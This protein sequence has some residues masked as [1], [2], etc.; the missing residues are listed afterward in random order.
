M[1]Y[2]ILENGP[3]PGRRFSLTGESVTIGRLG[4][5][6]LAVG[7]SVVLFN[8]ELLAVSRR[9]AR[10]I[11]RGN[12]W[13]VMDGAEEGPSRN[14][15]Y[16]NGRRL[17]NQL[18]PVADGDRL[19]LCEPCVVKLAFWTHLPLPPED[20][21][22][23]LDG[24]PPNTVVIDGPLAE[25]D[26]SS[27]RILSRVDARDSALGRIPMTA[28]LES[29]FQAVL[30]IM[31]SL[32]QALGLDDVLPQVLNSL[33]KLF[34]QTDRGVIVLR[35][36][37][38]GLAPR[39]W[40]LRDAG[41]K[42]PRI[43]RS[44]AR[45]VMDTKHAARLEDW[46]KES[47]SST[48]DLRVRSVMCTPLLDAKGEPL[49]VMQLDTT[50]ANRRFTQADLEL[51]ATV[52]APAGIAVDNA[53]LH[54]RALRQQQIEFDLELANEVLLSFLP[55]RRPQLDDYEFFDF[56]R[57]ANR[58]GGD[59]FDYLTLPDGR[60]A[61]LVAD[62]VGKGVAA[63][64]MM[65]RVSGE[66]KFCLA[67][68][69]H[70]ATAVSK[71]NERLNG[72]QVE[73]FVTLV[74]AVLDPVRHEVTLVNAGHWPPLWRRADGTIADAGTGFSGLPL[75]VVEE[76]RYEQTVV[77]LAPGEFLRCTRTGSTRR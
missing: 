15:T 21:G 42:E 5:H 73:R 66:A 38:G 17:G 53:R 77:P 60:T 58:V 76:H 57:P 69:T 29:R 62:V 63:A 71:L 51:F 1:A 44:F 20:S 22:S 35:T 47:E 26:S 40:K 74:L 12:A 31:G 19:A 70:P 64:M 28:S 52:A 16:L 75:G 36:D 18:Q 68:E 6:G 37:D 7:R 34:A 61:V 39:W 25:D 46:P 11:R 27:S 56:Y 50:E 43:S 45:H 33:F 2:L 54:E 55:L 72:M 65:A 23:T 10:I 8:D 24:V 59:Y 4:K 3:E 13:F 32:G 14:G 67:S 30:E 41:Q 48:E 49:G 9:H